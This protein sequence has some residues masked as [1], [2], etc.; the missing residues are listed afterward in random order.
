VYR[1]LFHL[2]PLCVYVGAVCET[3]T[4]LRAV[5]NVNAMRSDRDQRNTR[6][7]GRVHRAQTAQKIKRLARAAFQYL[8]DTALSVILYL[9]PARGE[10]NIVK[11]PAR[12]S[13]VA[14]VF[15]IAQGIG[16]S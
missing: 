8:V 4:A 1:R 13:S 10:S 3:V 14:G 15:Q 7:P 5:V 11:W 12:G 2:P 9:P 16:H 6:L